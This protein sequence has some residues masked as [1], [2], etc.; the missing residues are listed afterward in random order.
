MKIEQLRASIINLE[1]GTINKEGLEQ[2]GL[3]AKLAADYILLQR[4]NT[5]L[6]SQVKVV[7]EKLKNY[8]IKVKKLNNK[9]VELLQEK[10]SYNNMH[11][12]KENINTQNFANFQNQQGEQFYPVYQFEEKS[13]FN[14]EN[15]YQPNIQRKMYTIPHRENPFSFENNRMLRTGPVVNRIQNN[16]DYVD[17]ESEDGNASQEFYKSLP[18]DNLFKKAVQNETQYLSGNGQE[19]DQYLGRFNNSGLTIR[20]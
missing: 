15:T 14:N 4:K 12:L 11:S 13:Q 3:P 7:K 9:V 16:M 8:K 18:V 1:Q 19:N 6:I 10:K 20:K 17:F 2:L 5:L